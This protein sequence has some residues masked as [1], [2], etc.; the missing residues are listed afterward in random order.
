MVGARPFQFTNLK[1]GEGLQPV[2]RFIETEG[3]LVD[4]QRQRG[5]LD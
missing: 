5:G 2:I 4:I 3:M 1:T